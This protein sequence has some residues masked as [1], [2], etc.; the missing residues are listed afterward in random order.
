MESVSKSS[1][2]LYSPGSTSTSMLRHV[3]EGRE[4]AWKEF[5]EKYS[6]MIHCI[7]QKNNLSEE[8]CDD[9]KIDV[10]TIFWRKMNNFLYDP[11][12]G[13][14]RNYLGRIAFFSALKRRQ[15]SPPELPADELQDYP[16]YIDET[17]MTEWKNF[18]LEE[19][20]KDLKEE[21]DTEIYQIFEMSF[22]QG[23]PAKEISAITRRTANNIYVIRSR[24]LKK[25]RKI[26]SVYREMEEAELRGRSSRKQ[27][28]QRE[29]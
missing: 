20:L 3:Q 16:E 19:A 26:I 13:K 7:G 15:Q 29:L 22:I 11:E 28:E 4:E 6:G 14:F 2:V 24:C 21:L 9:L 23:R 25:L 12:K 10:M 27:L 1:G 17:I 5:Y 8:E 18:L